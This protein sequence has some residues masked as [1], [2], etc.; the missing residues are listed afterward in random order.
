MDAHLVPQR[1]EEFFVEGGEEQ[2]DVT[3]GVDVGLFDVFLGIVAVLLQ[4]DARRRVLLDDAFVDQPIA[5]HAKRYQH[6]VDGL[7]RVIQFDQ[8]VLERDDVLALDLPHILLLDMLQ[9]EGQ[10]DCV[11]AQGVFG[12][13]CAVL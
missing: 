2:V 1:G 9:N 6:V 12:E 5:Q 10:L 8:F 13:H 11:V 3:I 7:S 4:S